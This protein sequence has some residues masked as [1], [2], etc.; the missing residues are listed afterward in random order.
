MNVINRYGSLLGRDG[1]SPSAINPRSRR[2]WGGFKAA[3]DARRVQ[4]SPEEVRAIVAESESREDVY[5]ELA[6]LTGMT[7]D[8]LRGKIARSASLQEAMGRFYKPR[9]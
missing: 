9:R 2:D 6:K 4:L 7:R 3:N 1:A 8:G 5:T